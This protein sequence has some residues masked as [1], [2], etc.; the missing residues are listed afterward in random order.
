[1][2]NFFRNAVNKARELALM[3]VQGTIVRDGP[4]NYQRGWEAVGGWLALSTEELVFV[5][6]RLNLQKEPLVISL[7]R[8]EQCYPCWTKFLGFIPL[9]PNGMALRTT[10]GKEH[11]FVL[12]GRHDWIDAIQPQ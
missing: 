11:R 7:A 10:D 9:L 6:H 1:M 3:A 8:I 2:I 5:A 12:F 4:A